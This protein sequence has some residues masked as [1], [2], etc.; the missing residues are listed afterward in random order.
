M[1]PTSSPLSLKNS[2]I[3]LLAVLA[4]CNTAGNNSVLG[5][6]ATPAAAN[7][8]ENPTQ[9]TRLLNTRTD[10]SDYCPR[11]NLQE[12][13]AIYQVFRRN[14]KQDDADNL[15]YQATIL[16]FSR[17][18]TY[19]QGQLRMRIGVAGRLISGPEGK[20]GTFEMPLRIAIKSGEEM[21]FN[22]LYR[23]DATIAPG[24]ANGN[25]SF[26]DNE[27][28]IPAPTSRSLR[29]RVGFDEGKNKNP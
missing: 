17:N 14:A 24:T 13:T 5:S 28:W 3:L 25:F 11:I 16:R 8:A 26:V 15:R 10:L 20:P 4:G 2:A 19:E 29:V 6:A 22:K 18:C 12:G 23:I 21:V 7:N 27:V 1:S 9:S